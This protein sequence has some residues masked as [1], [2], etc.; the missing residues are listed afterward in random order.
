MEIS[1]EATAEKGCVSP[2][3]SL[4]SA[5][6]C[7]SSSQSFPGSLV[8]SASMCDVRKQSLMY[9]IVRASYV[10]YARP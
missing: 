6:L 5:G 1:S 7:F 4:A 3:L 8:G 9:K 2:V 10:S